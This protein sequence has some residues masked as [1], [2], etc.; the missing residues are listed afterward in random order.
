MHSVTNRMA[1]TIKLEGRRGTN[2]VKRC[3]SEKA[4]EISAHVCEKRPCFGMHASDELHWQSKE[5]AGERQRKPVT[6]H[7]RKVR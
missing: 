3:S 4:G 5:A 2:H 1:G 7:E 6:A